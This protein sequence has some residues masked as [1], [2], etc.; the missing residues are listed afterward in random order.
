[1][2][3]SW[4]IEC[5]IFGRSCPVQSFSETRGLLRWDSCSLSSMRPQTRSPAP[6]N[7]PRQIRSG[8]LLVKQWPSFFFSFKSAKVPRISFFFLLQKILLVEFTVLNI[9]SQSTKYI[10]LK[11]AVLFSCSVFDKLTIICSIPYLYTISCVK[12]TSPKI[13]Y[14]SIL[15]HVHFIHD[16]RPIRI[17]IDK[18]QPMNEII[19]SCARACSPSV[20]ASVCICYRSNR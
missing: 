6:D 10:S 18:A 8:I 14:L 19:E 15:H 16:N 2:F 17:R 13:E 1:M 3:T 12:C 20:Y 11:V 4:Q 7:F 5:L 9:F